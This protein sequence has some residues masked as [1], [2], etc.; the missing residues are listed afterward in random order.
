MT[1]MFVLLTEHER[2]KCYFMISG[3]PELYTTEDPE[4]LETVTGTSKKQ[5]RQRE[6]KGDEG[7]RE[8]RSPGTRQ[9]CSQSRQSLNEF[10]TPTVDCLGKSFLLRSR[11][12]TIAP[13]CYVHNS[14]NPESNLDPCKPQNYNVSVDP[15]NKPEDKKA[16]TKT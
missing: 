4:Q 7:R 12:P 1:Q 3:I 8:T 9:Q 13:E 2:K 11:C 10:R 15:M 5:W 6:T 16:R 14:T